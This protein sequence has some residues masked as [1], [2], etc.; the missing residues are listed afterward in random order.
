MVNF[1]REKIK[2]DIVVNLRYLIK[3]GWLGKLLASIIL[4]ILIFIPA[5]FYFL[6]NF[7]TEP[8]GFWQNFGIIFLWVIVF[9][10][11][12]L[13]F[14]IFGGLIILICWDPYL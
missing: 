3:Y 8:I 6:I 10:I 7:L 12:Q 1:N 14:L 13:G 11:P 2:Q 4:L 5:Y 9:G